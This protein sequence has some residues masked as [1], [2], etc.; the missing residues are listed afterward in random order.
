MS[1]D[2]LKISEPDRPKY[3]R[4]AIFEEAFGRLHRLISED[5]RLIA[6]IGRISLILPPELESL[7]KGHIGERIGLIRTDDPKKE[8]RIRVDR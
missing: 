6:F 8:Y 2:A 4:L 7:L 1:N 3:Y 5:G